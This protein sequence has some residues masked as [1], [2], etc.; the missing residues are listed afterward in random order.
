MYYRMD[1]NNNQYIDTC[2]LLGNYSDKDVYLYTGA[3]KLEY[4]APRILYEPN[5]YCLPKWADPDKLTFMQAVKIINYRMRNNY[6]RNY[7]SMT[8]MT[9]ITWMTRTTG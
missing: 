3:A 1:N 9:G 6:S 2:R 5:H 4:E 8:W 7:K